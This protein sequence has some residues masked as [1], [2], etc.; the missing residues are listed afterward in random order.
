[1]ETG[2]ENEVKNQKVKDVYFV[3]QLR[4]MRM[5]LCISITLY[6][7]VIYNTRYIILIL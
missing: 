4:Y 5:L 6:V 7:V 3:N 2:G 1:M